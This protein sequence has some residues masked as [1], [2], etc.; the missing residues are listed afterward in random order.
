VSINLLQ[1]QTKVSGN[2]TT[3]TTWTRAGSPY[4]LTSNVI[5]DNGSTLTIEPGAVVEAKGHVYLSMSRPRKTI[6][7]RV[8]HPQTQGKIERHHRSMKNIVKL[9]NYYHPEQLINAIEDFV[10]YYNHQRYHESLQ[11][12]NPSDVY[13]GRQ[14]QIL[15]PRALIKHQSL[16][17]RKQLFLKEKVLHLNKETLYN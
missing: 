14:E 4:N 15:P 1:A 17:S 13:Y 16:K 6:H 8:M 11:N 10:E 7:G 5:V 3:N 2:I 12:V 9:E